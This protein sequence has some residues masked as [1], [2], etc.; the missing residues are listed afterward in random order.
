ME[1]SDSIHS[2]DYMIP[3]QLFADRDT[4]LSPLTTKYP[5]T[6]YSSN[7]VINGVSAGQKSVNSQAITDK[8]MN[9]KS[10]AY[11]SQ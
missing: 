4:Y 11:M 6:V 9:Y 1:I 2:N 10:P 8:E 5:T 7:N 3:I